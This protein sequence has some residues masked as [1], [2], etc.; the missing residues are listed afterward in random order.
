M[1]IIIFRGEARQWR[2]GHFI[3]DFYSVYIRDRLK[4]PAVRNV[5][6]RVICLPQADL[7]GTSCS[8]ET[9]NRDYNLRLVGR[10]WQKSSFDAGFLESFEGRGGDIQV[11][12]TQGLDVG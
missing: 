9:R 5:P 10:E 3:V 11:L 4:Y 8:T 12:I 7:T 1:S 6:D 2:T